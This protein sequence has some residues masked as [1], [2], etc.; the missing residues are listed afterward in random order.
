MTLTQVGL[1]SDDTFQELQLQSLRTDFTRDTFHIFQVLNL[2]FMQPV[3]RPVTFVGLVP[4]FTYLLL[5]LSHILMSV[6][7]RTI[8]AKYIRGTVKL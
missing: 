7:L 2:G 4:I 6:I 3:K 8:L 5:S 1:L